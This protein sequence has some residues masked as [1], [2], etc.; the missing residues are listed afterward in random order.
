[1]SRYVAVRVVMV[2]VAPIVFV[3]LTHGQVNSCQAQVTC[4][5]YSLY[6]GA[7]IPPMPLGAHSCS[8]NGPWSW[9]CSVPT[10]GCS[11]SPCPTCNTSQAGLPI[12]LGTGNTYI[13][14]T[15]VR[16]PGLGGGFGLTRTWNSQTTGYGMFGLGWTSN[17]EERIYIG[18]DYLLKHLKGSGGIWSYGFSGYSQDGSKVEYLQAG[19]RNSGGICL[20]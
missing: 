18:G 16:L 12:D 17:V 8:W 15:D 9:T 3:A 10:S 14:E 13:E 19:P 1:M 6:Y 4:S 5:V 20:A 2:F 7:C 11:P